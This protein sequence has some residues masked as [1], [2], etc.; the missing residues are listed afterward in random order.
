MGP[1]R[2]SGEGKS[3]GMTTSWLKVAHFTFLNKTGS[4]FERSLQISLL[5]V[6]LQPG[7]FLDGPGPFQGKKG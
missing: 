5:G 1:L 7:Q 4:F 6:K 3:G 2:L